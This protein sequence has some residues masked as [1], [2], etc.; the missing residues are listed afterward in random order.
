MCYFPATSKCLNIKVFLLAYSG[1][2]DNCFLVFF[3][4]LLFIIIFFPQWKI[5]KKKKQQTKKGESA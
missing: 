4:Y 3:F 2:Y 5:K 1:I